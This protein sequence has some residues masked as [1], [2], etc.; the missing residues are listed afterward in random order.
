MSSSQLKVTS[1]SLELCVL[2][3]SPIPLSKSFKQFNIIIHVNIRLR[4]K[5][6]IDGHKF[7]PLIYNPLLYQRHGWM[8]GLVFYVLFNSISVMVGQWQ[9]VQSPEQI[10]LRQAILSTTK[11]PTTLLKRAKIGK[12]Q[13]SRLHFYNL[14][15]NNWKIL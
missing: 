7:E 10:P 9:G 11:C 13:F 5:V 2:S 12:C 4:V 15:Y 14:R 3:I 1:L 8:D 6:T